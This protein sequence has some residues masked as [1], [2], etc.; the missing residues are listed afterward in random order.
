[1]VYIPHLPRYLDYP[2]ILGLHAP[3]P[4]LVLA[5]DRDPL[6]TLEE[7][8]VAAD[9]LTAIYDKASVPDAFA[10]SMHEGPHRFDVPMQEEAFDWF[11]RWLKTDER[12]S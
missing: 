11:D 8:R 6:F 12:V 4:A 2:E 7:V 1:M 10:F 9:M 5:T 3:Y